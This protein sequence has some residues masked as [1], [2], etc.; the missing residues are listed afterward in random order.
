MRARCPPARTSCGGCWPGSSP[1]G[2]ILRSSQSPQPGPTMPFFASATN[3]RCGC[4]VSAG[5][6]GRWTRNSH[7][8]RSS[9]PSCRSRSRLRWQK[10]SP[11]KAIRGPGGCT[12]GSRANLRPST[13][14]ATLRRRPGTSPGFSRRC[15]QSM[16][17]M[18]QPPGATTLD[19]ACHWRLVTRP[20]VRPSRNGQ[21]NSTPARLSRPGMLRSRQNHGQAH[22]NGSMAT[23]R[24]AICSRKTATSRL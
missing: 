16:P 15:S 3:S 13:G 1:R 6:P 24:R 4:H 23:C 9:R 12:A 17:A 2:P 21:A 19:E 20:L 7:G 22:R 10:A 8:C 11:A 18:D 14:L 5:P